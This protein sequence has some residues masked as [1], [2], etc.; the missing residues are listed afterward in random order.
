MKCI[1]LLIALFLSANAYSQ[2]R[3]E[4]TDQYRKIS[5]SG[6]MRI[7][8]ARSLERADERLRDSLKQ[9]R[10]KY[11]VENLDRSWEEIMADD[12]VRFKPIVLEYDSPGG[13]MTELEV[14]V[15]TVE[16]ISRYSER[17]PV[18]VYSYISGECSSA[19][20]FLYLFGSERYARPSAKIALHSP[21]RNDRIDWGWWELIVERVDRHMGNNWASTTPYFRSTELTVLLPEDLVDERNGIFPGGESKHL[22]IPKHF[23]ELVAE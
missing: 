12:S 21:S 11:A 13:L 9:E 10:I 5:I 1:F 7:G 19:C 15:N 18:K 16:A 14:A 3:F 20:F 23:Y 2:V 22:K 4:E 6:E 17:Y 8:F